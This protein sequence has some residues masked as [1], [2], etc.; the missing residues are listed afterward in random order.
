MALI[1]NLPTA[2]G[3]YLLLIAQGL[4][5]LPALGRI[6]LTALVQLT[7]GPGRIARR[8]RDRRRKETCSPPCAPSSPIWC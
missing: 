3:R 6:V 4:A 7:G 8:W 2:V 5:A 1:L